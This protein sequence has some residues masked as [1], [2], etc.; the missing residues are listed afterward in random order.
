M[1]EWLWHDMSY[2][3]KFSPS[4]F[5][6]SFPFGTV[7]HCRIHRGASGG[8]T[9]VGIRAWLSVEVFTVAILKCENADLLDCSADLRNN[10]Y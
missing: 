3:K 10:E 5:V 4:T 7:M 6:D 9:G 2:S 8:V 1:L